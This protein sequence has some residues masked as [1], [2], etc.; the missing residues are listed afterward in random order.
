MADI[1][2]DSLMKT[3]PGTHEPATNDVSLDIID[4]EFMVLLGPSGCGKT[5][6]LRMI[7]GLE[8]PDSG[9][10]AIG[11]KDITYLPPQDR[12][13]SMVFQ[14]YAVFPHRRVRDNIAFG[15]V[16]QKLPKATVEEK[17]NRAA[18]ILG[19]EPYLDRFPA[20]LSGGQRQRVAVARAIVMDAD[21]MLMDEPLSNLDALRLDFR[22][23]LKKIVQDIGTTTV[24]VTH[25]QVE[26]L[27]LSDRVAVMRK[28][29]IV[30]LGDP[31][32]VYDV[33]ATTFVG[34]FLGSPPMNF[35]DTTLT[36]DGSLR[37]GDQQIPAP[38][39][40]RAGSRQGGNGSATE[41]AVKL[42][43]RAENIEVVQSGGNGYL[44]ARVLVVEPLG[45]A[46]LLTADVEGQTL[47]VQ[48][49]PTVRTKPGQDLWLHLTPE[50]LRC[51]D[52]ETGLAMLDDKV[53]A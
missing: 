18:E 1:S 37:V 49:P 5:T 16:M 6:L 12:N 23:E 26:A 34:G 11:G 28:G 39:V 20:Q 48:T 32:D 14:S 40:L 36:S 51:Y 43:V 19:L 8:V 3:Y 9:S 24:Y 13:L 35:L 33:P 44:R 52:G 21:V 42:G 17:V 27:S 45:S 7:A 29:E 22:A 41:Q 47:K 30:Q 2:I 50:A 15:L 25:D 46:T 10:I 31:I 38:P 53:R 4:G